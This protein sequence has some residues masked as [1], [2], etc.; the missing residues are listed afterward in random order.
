MSSNLS[1]RQ[2]VEQFLEPSTA[3]KVARRFEARG[4]DGK[5]VGKDC[6]LQWSRGQWLIEELPQKGKRKLKVGSMQNPLGILNVGA[7]AFIP[8]NIL[9]KAKPSKSDGYEALQKKIA[10]AM[11]EAVKATA[12]SGLAPKWVSKHECKWYDNEVFYLEIVPEDVHPFKAE[13]KDFSVAVAWTDFKAYSPNSDLQQADPHYTII[14]Q[15]SPGAA[16]KLYNTLTTEPAALKS[17]PWNKFTDW[18]N[19]KKIGYEMRFSQW[20]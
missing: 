12:E 6:R 13:G 19:T 2:A 8:E 3:M 1:I 7:D 16:R 10:E 11:K 17:I 4:F 18:L 15:K 14:E 20:T 9:Q 5:F